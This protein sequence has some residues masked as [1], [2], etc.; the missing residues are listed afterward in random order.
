MKRTDPWT[1]ML[2]FLTMLCTSWAVIVAVVN[3]VAAVL[4]GVL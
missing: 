1:T 2:A 4:S 3:V